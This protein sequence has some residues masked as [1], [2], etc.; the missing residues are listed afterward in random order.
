[1]R[2]P[3]MIQRLSSNILQI[4]ISGNW[5]HNAYRRGTQVS[6]ACTLSFVCGN[7]A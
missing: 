3:Y 2:L 7:W 1:M 6:I 4:S 5:I